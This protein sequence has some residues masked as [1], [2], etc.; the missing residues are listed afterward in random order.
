M[1]IF[2]S[3]ISVLGA[4]NTLLP[5]PT[6]TPAI[7]SVSILKLFFPNIVLRISSIFIEICIC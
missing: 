2:D 7:C 5:T 1:N 4:L 6:L 3:E